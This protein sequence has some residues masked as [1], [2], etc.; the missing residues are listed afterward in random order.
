MGVILVSGGE[1]RF[2]RSLRDRKE[3]REVVFL[4]RREMDIM[5]PSSIEEAIHR[6]SPDSF[7]HSAALS[8]PMKVH[9]EDPSS[10]IKLNI[11]GTSN[12]VLSCIKHKI[13]FVYLSTDFVYPGLKGGYKET[14][15]VLPV[16]KY[17]WSKLGGECSSL[18]YENSLVLRISMMES[19]FPHKRAFSDSIRSLL[20]Q[21][22]VADLVYKMIDLDCRGIYNVGG[23]KRSVYEFVSQKFPEVEAETSVGLADFI[24]PDVSM[25]IKKIKN[26]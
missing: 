20:W 8:R 23:E 25:N 22:E 18:L 15:P 26:L 11:I 2:S 4:G 17:A 6:Y 3:N 19:P 5:D 21:E 24:P 14:D 10:S 13:K 7:I 16:N 9:E 1:G 12:C